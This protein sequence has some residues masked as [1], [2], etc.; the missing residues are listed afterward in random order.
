MRLD[1]IEKH[2]HILPVLSI[3]KHINPLTEQSKIVFKSNWD[4]YYTLKIGWLFWSNF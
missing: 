2:F 3:T 4:Y 1:P